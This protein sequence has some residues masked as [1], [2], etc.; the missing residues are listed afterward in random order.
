MDAVSIRRHLVQCGYRPALIRSG[1]ELA[2]GHSADLV[3]F[4][5]SPADARSACIAVLQNREP[6]DEV[7]R[8]CQPLGA[9]IVFLCDSERLQWWSQDA[10]GPRAIRTIAASEAP[11]FFQEHREDF[12]PNRVYRAKTWARFDKDFQLSFVDCGLMGLVEGQIGQSLQELIERNV[13]ALK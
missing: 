5:H 4:A 2:G 7:V 8:A 11:R 1:V 9:P 3:A 10:T 6:S 12:Q 13:T